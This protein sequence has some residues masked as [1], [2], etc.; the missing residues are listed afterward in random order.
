MN[1][2]RQG[3]IKVIIPSKKE[4]KYCIGSLHIAS[5]ILYICLGKL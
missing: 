2:S 1:G 5:E 3:E 4:I